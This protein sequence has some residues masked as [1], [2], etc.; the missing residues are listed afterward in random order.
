MEFEISLL[1]GNKM[2]DFILDVVE[3]E[4]EN[5]LNNTSKEN[6]LTVKECWNVLFDQDTRSNIL[7]RLGVI[8]WD[9]YERAI[10]AFLLLGGSILMVGP[11]G[12]GKT[13]LAKKLGKALGVPMATYDASKSVWEDIMGFPDP[14]KL[15]NLELRKD[16]VGIPRIST[17]TTI[18]GKRL[19]LVDEIN[20]ATPE[21]QSKW[22]EVILNQTVMGEAT[23]AKWII[24]AMNPGYAGTNPLDLA[25][26][27]RYMFFLNA[28]MGVRMEPAAITRVLELENPEETPAIMTWNK[29]RTFDLEV[30]DE[31][32]PLS[33][34][35]QARFDEAARVLK[36]ILV[37]ASD[38]MPVIREHWNDS[39][40]EYIVAVAKNLLSEASVPTDLRRLRMMKNALLAFLALEAPV[41]GNRSLLLNS[42]RVK[43]LAHDL[44]LISYPVIAGLE[45]PTRAQLDTA[46]QVASTLLEDRK[47][48]MFMIGY[49]ADPIRKLRLLFEFKERDYVF[50]YKILNDLLRP[51]K[52]KPSDSSPAY[53]PFALAMALLSAYREGLVLDTQCLSII[54]GA[55]SDFLPPQKAYL[56]NET[57]LEKESDLATCT[58]F[59]K[60]VNSGKYNER[61]AKYI[62]CV[63]NL[64]L[65]AH[66]KASLR[67]MMA[68]VRSMAP[69]I[70][71]F[72]DE[73]YKMLI[74]VIPIANAAANRTLFEPESEDE[75]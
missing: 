75:E 4:R 6:T 54:H 60:W 18:H 39:V 14:A 8:G 55:I 49:E 33:F 32:A 36:S 28:P 11:H 30:S 27:S 41:S 26:A 66:D 58:E 64:S 44:L 74:E 51:D 67:R 38:V 16:Y 72:L 21:M 56:M 13:M 43:E 25:L 12:E 61:L 52:D 15:M 2:S 7:E 53:A 1:K 19:I 59:V 69:S 31:Y 65:H 37:V 57:A 34:E 5:I 62:A 63:S 22:L 48:P 23:G 68:S 47:S 20:R 3:A 9:S 40:N 17:P 42:E 45:G 29:A 50:T 10:E 24:S 73:A 46:H 71:S 35:S 70:Q